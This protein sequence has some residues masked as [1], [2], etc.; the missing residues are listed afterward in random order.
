MKQPNV[1][2]LLKTVKMAHHYHYRH[3]LHA[4]EWKRKNK[5]RW[6]QYNNS[7]GHSHISNSSNNKK[8]RCN[9]VNRTPMNKVTVMMVHSWVL[10]LILPWWERVFYVIVIKR[11]T[12]VVVKVI[13]TI[14]VIITITDL[15]NVYLNSISYLRP[16]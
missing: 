2:V 9:T 8:K 7:N 14:I 4:N 16:I 3:P 11:H 15:I 12:H 6:S 5:N 1:Q 13:T 10:T